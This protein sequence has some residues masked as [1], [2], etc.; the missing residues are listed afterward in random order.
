MS[1]VEIKWPFMV[2]SVKCLHGFK[3]D[4]VIRVIVVNVFLFL[5]L[6][7]PG[8]CSSVCVKPKFVAGTARWILHLECA[9]KAIF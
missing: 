7:M 9:Y 2:M 5:F 8:K 1:L 6:S 3:C 4:L